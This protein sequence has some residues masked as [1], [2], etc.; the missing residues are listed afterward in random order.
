MADLQPD[1]D[2]SFAYVFIHGT[3]DGSSVIDR[4]RALRAKGLEEDPHILFAATTVGP[5]RGIAVIK[6][7]DF[8]GLQELL[9]GEGD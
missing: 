3:T 6:A 2:G 8:C 9:G 5:Y 7:D 1:P 4:I